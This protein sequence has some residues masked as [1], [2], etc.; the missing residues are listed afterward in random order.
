[1]FY[2]LVDLGV[3]HKRIPTWVMPNS[4]IAIY[5]EDP[6]AAREKIR[7]D[8]MVVELT[9]SEQQRYGN[10]AMA[11]TA[12][13]TALPTKVGNRARKVWILEGGYCSDTKYAEK[14]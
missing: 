6:V 3:H 13:H 10:G 4:I 7:P 5:H 2:E 12:C 11:N 9:K 14:L 8:V 1:M